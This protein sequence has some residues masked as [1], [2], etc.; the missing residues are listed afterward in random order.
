MR[1]RWILLLLAPAA[2]NCAAHRD[3]GMRASHSFVELSLI[4]RHG[5]RTFQLGRE[6]LQVEPPRFTTADLETA[7]VEEDPQAPGQYLV[8]ARLIPEASRRFRDTTA[9]AV[10]SRVAVVVDD[11]LTLAPVLREAVDGRR[12]PL[13]F[14]LTQDNAAGLA[15]AINSHRH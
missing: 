8:A 6:R 14:H 5:G 15:A 3:A 12:V 13:V 11:T 9:G 4:S 1:K 10:G 2:L 7:Y